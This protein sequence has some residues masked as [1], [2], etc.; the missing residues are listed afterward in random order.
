MVFF[1]SLSAQVQVGANDK[2]W[3]QSVEWGSDFLFVY[4]RIY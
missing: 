3:V 1:E 4:H 2:D